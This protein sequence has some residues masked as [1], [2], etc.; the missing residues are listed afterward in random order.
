MQL[1]D[2]LLFSAS[3]REIRIMQSLGDL[4][5]QNFHKD[6]RPSDATASGPQEEFKS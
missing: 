6:T 2:R 1:Q 4:K 5:C 3:Q